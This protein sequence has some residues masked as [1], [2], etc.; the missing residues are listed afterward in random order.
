M[1]AVPLASMEI[2]KPLTCD[3]VPVWTLDGA[4]TIRV[5]VPTQK[6]LD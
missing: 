4:E 3:Y 2:K 5:A 1:N 6:Q